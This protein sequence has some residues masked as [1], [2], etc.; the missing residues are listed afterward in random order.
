MTRPLLVAT[1]NHDLRAHL[2]W[3]ESPVARADTLHA[4]LTALRD[5]PVSP[6]LAVGPDVTW[7]YRGPQIAP[8]PVLLY[9]EALIVDWVGVRHLG[10]E[11]AFQLSDHFS[12][13]G[14]RLTDQHPSQGRRRRPR[15]ASKTRRAR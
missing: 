2:M 14:Q 1:A 6:L 4:A 8:V 12:H 10:I 13:L 9:T 5:D 3:L 11:H 7:D 15:P